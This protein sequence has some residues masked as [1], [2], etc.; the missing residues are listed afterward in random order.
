M[1]QNSRCVLSLIQ[2]VSVNEIGLKMVKNY[3]EKKNQKP[4]QKLPKSEIPNPN[5]WVKKKFFQWKKYS[6]LFNL[7]EKKINFLLSMKSILIVFSKFLFF[8]LEVEHA[9]RTILCTIN[10]SHEKG[11]EMLFRPFYIPYSCCMKRS[12][13]LF[14]PILCTI[15][16]FVCEKRMTIFATLWLFFRDMGNSLWCSSSTTEGKTD[17]VFSL[18]YLNLFL[19]VDE[20]FCTGLAWFGNNFGD[21]VLKTFF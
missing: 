14:R 18:N 11:F 21:T 20:C 9:F 17:K 4:K 12:C 13:M 3:D 8:F 2:K 1:K 10:R 5:L 15:K 7:W 6:Y 19:V 16:L